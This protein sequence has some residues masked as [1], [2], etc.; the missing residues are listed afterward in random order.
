M[1][2]N[3]C[4]DKA[5]YVLMEHLFYI[6]IGDIIKILAPVI[7]KVRGD[8]TMDY[9][10]CLEKRK[11]CVYD[12]DEGLYCSRG[13]RC[14]DCGAKLVYSEGCKRCPVCGYSPCG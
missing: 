2:T 3:K 4:L 11:E 7:L 6:M 9:A 5:Y 12:D 13:D 10:E 14:P 1:I 8:K